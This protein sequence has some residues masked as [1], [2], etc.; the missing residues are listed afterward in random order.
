MYVYDLG[1]AKCRY[2]CTESEYY[3]YCFINMERSSLPPSQFCSF[4]W[5]IVMRH[6]VMRHARYPISLTRS[7]NSLLGWKLW[8]RVVLDAEVARRTELKIGCE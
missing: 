4:L 7:R 2:N 5:S 1:L 6:A 3:E 8:C